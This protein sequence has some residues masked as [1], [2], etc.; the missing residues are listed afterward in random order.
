MGSRKGQAVIF[1][2]V[3]IF[4]ISVSIFVVCYAVFTIYQFTYFT[5]LG[6]ADQLGGVRDFVSTHIVT[7]SQVDGDRSVLLQIPRQAG[8]DE[9]VIRLSS[10]GLNVSTST[11]FKSSN[12]Y[13]LGESFDLDGATASVR[14]KITLKKVGN[15][16]KIE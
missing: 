5:P 15:Q 3:L 2:N 10:D 13:G 1:E 6:T 8:N 12:L 4:A 11:D 16:I 7:L 9:Y 14:G